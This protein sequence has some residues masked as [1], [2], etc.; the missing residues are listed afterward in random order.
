MIRS[1]IG[2]LL[3]VQCAIYY[4]EYYCECLIL[5]SV[6]VAGEFSIKFVQLLIY[7]VFKAQR[8]TTNTPHRGSRKIELTHPLSS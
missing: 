3:G 5:W 2:K 7:K 4:K 1:G 8:K 6:L